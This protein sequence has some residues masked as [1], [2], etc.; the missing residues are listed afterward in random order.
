[1]G[2]LTSSKLTTCKSTEI[3]AATSCVLRQSSAEVASANL[4][5]PGK[6]LEG[7]S[8][9]SHQLGPL[10]CY[11]HLHHCA[12]FVVVLSIRIQE[13]YMDC[14]GAKIGWPWMSGL[15]LSALSLVPDMVQGKQVFRRQLQS[16]L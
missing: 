6:F 13:C 3:M 11:F 9:A 16:V 12:T 10:C 5:G 1:M 8:D 15:A 7:G 2:K 14:A 4:R